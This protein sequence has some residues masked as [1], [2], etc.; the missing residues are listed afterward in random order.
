TSH[1]IQALQNEQI[2]D[3]QIVRRQ[4][5]N[6]RLLILDDLGVEKLTESWGKGKLYEIIESRYSADLPMIITTN[7]TKEELS[8]HVGGRT[9]DRIRSMCK[10]VGLSG[11]SRRETL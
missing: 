6:V 11:E 10:S 9:A 3:D 5:Q 4:C 2:S 7:S 1:L 8:E